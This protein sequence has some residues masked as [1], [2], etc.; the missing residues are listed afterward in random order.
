MKR[1]SIGAGG[2]VQGVCFRYY[3]QRTAEELGLTGWVRNVHGGRIE[4]V[5]EGDDNEVDRMVK[6]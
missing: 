1:V 4:A 2:I 3:A 5:I 6:W